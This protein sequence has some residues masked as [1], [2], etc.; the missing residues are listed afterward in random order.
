MSATSSIC[1]CAPHVGN[2]VATAAARPSVIP[3]CETRPVQTY[4]PD[5]VLDIRSAQSGAHANPDQPDARG[6]EPDGR[7][8]GR[9]ERVE[10]QRCTNGNEEDDQQRQCARSD[11]RLQR[12]PL[13]DGDVGDDDAGRH[14]R[15]QRFDALAHAD[16][17]QHQRHDKQRQR[18]FAADV[19]ADTARRA[20]R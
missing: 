19:P 3:A 5:A 13:R 9:R 12:V 4:S 17:A 15:K 14:R 6:G 8:T 2:S 10:P 16:L 1:T 18:H 11:R 7:N 20:R